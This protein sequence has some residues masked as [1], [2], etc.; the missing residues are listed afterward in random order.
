M[1]AIQSGPEYRSRTKIFS[2]YP[3]LVFVTY[4]TTNLFI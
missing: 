4:P 3:T 1:V 2:I